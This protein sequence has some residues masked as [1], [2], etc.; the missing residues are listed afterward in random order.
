MSTNT[1]IDINS[2]RS[3]L[4]NTET[5]SSSRTQTQYMSGNG[6]DEKVNYVLPN[7]DDE[8]DRLHQQHW[9]LKYIFGCNYHAPIH[10]LLEKGIKVLDSGCGPATWCFDM[11]EAYPNSKFQGIDISRVF[12]ESIKP[13]N[14]KFVNGNIAQLLP[15]ED[16]TFDYIHQ[17]LLV[18]G[19]THTDWENNL[20]EIYRV[21]KP[22]GYVEFAEPDIKDQINPGPLIQKTQ[23]IMTNMLLS[24]NMCPKIAVE[25]NEKLAA[26][27]FEDIT[28]I[29]KELPMGHN[30]KKGE[31]WW[32][33]YKHTTQNLR[34]AMSM[35][36]PELEDPEKFASFLDEC[37]QECVAN[38]TSFRWV[39]TYAQ[40]Y[41][42]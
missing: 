41:K 36:D 28:V 37:R 20:K 24:R 17:R 42:I 13:I 2:E 3:S 5:Q 8:V 35:I 10:N 12:P 7:N 15:F 11:A 22:G 4:T 39:V 14:V 38:K 1:S 26:A 21:L 32:Q 9:I 27:G 31:L 16:N 19:L 40:K 33:D 29:E 18:G 25:L 23:N 6:C 34:S 30:E